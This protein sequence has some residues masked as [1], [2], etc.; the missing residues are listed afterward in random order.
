MPKGRPLPPM[1]IGQEQRQQLVS[2]IGR[3]KTAQ[4]LA[5][6]ARTVLLAAEGLS[7][8]A[9]AQQASTTLQTVGKWRRRFLE[10]GIDRLLDEARPGTSRKQ[11]RRQRLCGTNRVQTQQCKSPEGQA[12]TLTKKKNR[13]ESKI[14]AQVEHVFRI[15]RRVFGFDKVRYR[16]IAKNHNRL[17][18]NFALANR[19]LQPRW[20]AVLE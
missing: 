15:V 17:C 11:Q 4:A 20:L 18:S 12:A 19:Y 1:S 9:I 14:R 8:T 13:S 3:R 5:M 16:G 7:N 2:W 10:G 6:R